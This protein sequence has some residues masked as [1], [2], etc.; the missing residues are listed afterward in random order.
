M[1][2]VEGAGWLE[3]G[4]WEG[5]L[6]AF[7]GPEY[8]RAWA[9]NRSGRGQSETGRR[10]ARGH[11]YGRLSRAFRSS[12]WCSPQNSVEEPPDEWPSYWDGGP[13][14]P[15]GSR[16]RRLA[17]P[18]SNAPGCLRARRGVG[19]PRPKVPRTPRRRNGAASRAAPTRTAGR[20]RTRTVIPGSEIKCSFF[21]T[22]RGGWGLRGT[23]SGK[24]WPMRR[25]FSKRKD[26]TGNPTALLSFHG[27]FE[28]LAAV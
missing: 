7:K 19:L 28:F 13:G 6:F 27:K 20:G 23:P 2:G 16:S 3:G 17:P 8:R 18:A 24:R 5:R 15:R 11:A 9:L 26:K 4:V 12:A 22:Q 25:T 10:G 21:C 14:S 1:L